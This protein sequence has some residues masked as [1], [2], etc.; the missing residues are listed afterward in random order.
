MQPDWEMADDE[1]YEGPDAYVEGDEI[2]HG[3][4]EAL[5]EGRG[6]S[7]QS[8]LRCGYSAELCPMKFNPRFASQLYLTCS[9]FK[10]AQ[11]RMP[12]PDRHKLLGSVESAY[13]S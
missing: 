3:V 9:M 12:Q 4:E 5:T 2:E 6:R 7:V 8:I 1:A 11:V 10:R 13:T